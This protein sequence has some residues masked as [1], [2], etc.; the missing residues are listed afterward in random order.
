M[1]LKRLKAKIFEITRMDFNISFHSKI[2]VSPYIFHNIFNDNEIKCFIKGSCYSKC[3]NRCKMQL[4]N[5]NFE[6]ALIAQNLEIIINLSLYMI[7]IRF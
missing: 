6:N 3:I 5:S 4:F 7:K 1:N 2:I